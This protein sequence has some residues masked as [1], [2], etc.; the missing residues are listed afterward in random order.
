VVWD[1]APSEDIYAL[2]RAPRAV[3]LGGERVM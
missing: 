3:F 2:Q 1:G